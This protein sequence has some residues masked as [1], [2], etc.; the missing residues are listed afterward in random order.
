MAYEVKLP[1]FEGPLDLLIHLIRE[2]ELDI[3]D[4]PIATIT[5]Q[6]LAYLETMRSLNLDVAGEFLVMAATLTHIK[7]Q[8]LLPRP[9][10]EGLDDEGG[11][12]P[13]LEL[14][15][16]LL[17]YQRYKAAA[18]ELRQRELECLDTFAREAANDLSASSREEGGFLE[19]GLF[20]LLAALK[21]V[22]ARLPQE[23]FHEV[24]LDAI[25]VTD[26]INWLMSRLA[27][28]PRCV[29]QELFADSSSRMEMIV[30]FLALLEVVRLRLVRLVQVQRFGPIH[31]SLAVEPSLE[32]A[33]SDGP[34][35]SESHH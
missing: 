5:E 6:Y 25:S 7:S 10:L 21:E 8:M 34:P 23:S 13:R 18:V 29:F 9:T 20:D 35:A 28:T 2:N 15:E 33:A 1:F 27:E 14:V 16:R 22:L 19:V 31:V 24:T 30:T 11:V 26:R 3:Y 12:D 17:E 4:I 32:E